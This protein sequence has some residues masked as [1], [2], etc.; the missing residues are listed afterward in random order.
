MAQHLFKALV[1]V[2]E[3][4]VELQ[5]SDG[6]LATA[7]CSLGVRNFRWFW[8]GTCWTHVGRSLQVGVDCRFACGFF[9]PGR[10]WREKRPVPRHFSQPATISPRRR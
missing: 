7:L 4:F 5:R 10:A 6:V 1:E 3:D 8:H 9:W 2:V